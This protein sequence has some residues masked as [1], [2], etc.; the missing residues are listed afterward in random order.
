MGR[1]NRLISFHMTQTTQ[2]IMLPMILCRN[3]NN[4]FIGP[5]NSHGYTHRL[6]GWIS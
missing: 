2:K 5:L 4:V 6:I 1:S 3:G